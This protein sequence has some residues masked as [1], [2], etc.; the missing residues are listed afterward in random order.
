MIKFIRALAIIFMAIFI[1]ALFF[2]FFPIVM[3]IITVA[4]LFA[5]IWFVVRGVIELIKE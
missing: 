1:S 2:A 3:L 5:F 4:V